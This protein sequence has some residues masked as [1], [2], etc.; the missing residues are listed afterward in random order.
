M[1]SKQMNIEKTKTYLEDTIK[2]K[3][4]KASIRK[5]FKHIKKIIKI[6]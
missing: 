2:E 6:Y 1:L 3:I 5:I 4:S